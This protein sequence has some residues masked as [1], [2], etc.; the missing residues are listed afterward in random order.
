MRPA[1]VRFAAAAVLALWAAAN[2][3]GQEKPK[4]KEGGEAWVRLSLAESERLLRAS[5]KPQ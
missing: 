4:P 3:P 2:A 1:R 5:K